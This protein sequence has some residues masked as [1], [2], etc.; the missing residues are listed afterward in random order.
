MASYTQN[1]N[2]VKIDLADSPP[3][4]TVLN[5]NFDIIDEALRSAGGFVYMTESLPT[6]ERTA[7][8]LYALEVR[9]F[10]KQ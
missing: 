2:L 9:N 1:Y 8:K 3:D 10:N 7:N 6:D 5:Q 4:I